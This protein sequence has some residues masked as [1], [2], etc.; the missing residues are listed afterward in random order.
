LK[1]QSFSPKFLAVIDPIANW[2]SPRLGIC[3]DLSGSEL[4]LLRPDGSAFTTLE[5]EQQ[6][7]ERLAEKL[8]ELGVD[9]NQI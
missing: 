1:I 4:H 2:V 3:F 6:R 7:A 8:R 9:P 5:Q